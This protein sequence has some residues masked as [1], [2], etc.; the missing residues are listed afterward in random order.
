MLFISKNVCVSDLPEDALKHQFYQGSLVRCFLSR[1]CY[2]VALI[3]Y[4]K[5]PDTQAGD[6]DSLSDNY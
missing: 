5:P 2:P 1:C 3:R 6:G 4:K